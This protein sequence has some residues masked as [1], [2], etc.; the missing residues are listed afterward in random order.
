MKKIDDIQVN[1]L[2]ALLSIVLGLAIAKLLESLSEPLA[3]NLLQTF[4]TLNLLVLAVELLWTSA[5][6]V[7]RFDKLW[8]VPVYFVCPAILFLASSALTGG[9]SLSHNS[10]F[11]FWLASFH[12]VGLVVYQ[13]VIRDSNRIMNIIRVVAI[14]GLLLAGVFSLYESDRPIYHWG[15][16]IAYALGL[17]LYFSEKEPFP[18]GAQN[19]E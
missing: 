5:T 19:G 13:W 9:K 12:L 15:A 16:C 4:W 17:M 7:D 1:P 2:T 3:F 11:F 6:H 10:F 14:S 8:K 18:K